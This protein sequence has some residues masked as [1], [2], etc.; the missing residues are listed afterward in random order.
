MHFH[1]LLYDK[2]AK[3]LIYIKIFFLELVVLLLTVDVAVVQ[4]ACL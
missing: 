3:A 4:T 2:A 1:A